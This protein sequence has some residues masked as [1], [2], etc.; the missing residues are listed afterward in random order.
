[1]K[2]LKIFMPFVLCT[3]SIAVNAQKEGDT[4]VIG[5]Y[6]DG[7]HN[8]S[9]MHI[10]FNPLR[11]LIEYHYNEKLII[12]ETAANICDLNGKS[13]I[14]TNGMEIF[15]RGGNTIA[16]KIAYDPDPFSYWNYWDTDN[17][18]PLGFPEHDGALILPVPQSDDEYSVIYHFAEPHP[19]WIFQGSGFME[20]R[21]RVNADSSF[22][23]L[24]KDQFV[25]P[26]HYWYTTRINACRHANG[27]DWWILVSELDSPVYY[28]YL[29]DPGGIHLDHQ[30]DVGVTIE[31]GYGQSAFSNN[32]NYMVRMDEILQSEDQNITLFSFDRCSGDLIL[33]DVLHTKTAFLPGAAF[34]PSERYLYTDD[35][36]HLWQWDLLAED[37]A[38]SQTLVD[39]FDGFIEPGWFGTEFCSNGSRS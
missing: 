10:D 30:G 26:H 3:L 16:S 15:G 25:I 38:S 5:Y 13:L 24:S 17:H 11:P 9:V 6:A 19:T 39:S 28:S 36:T 7:T 33:L 4:W 14:W 1:M 21:I 34:S 29:L 31:Y 8:Y 35:N 20:A 27:R 22:T 12:S 23:L 18:G 37:I 2:I 32:G